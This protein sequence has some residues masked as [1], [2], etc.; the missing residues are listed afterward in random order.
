MTT[1]A[2]R[3]PAF[4]VF[5]VFLLLASGCA[6]RPFEARD[7]DKAAFLDRIVTQ[8]Q[9]AVRISA[10]VPTAE[11]VI[12]ITGLD[13]YARGIQPVWLRVENNDSRQVRVALLS[14]DS[15]YYSPME[16]AWYFR[17]GYSKDGK[18]AMERWLYEHGMPRIVPPGESRSGLVFT[19]LAEGTKGFNVDAYT[20]RQSFNFTFFVTMPGFEPDYMDVRFAELYSDD[21]IRVVDVPGLRTLLNDVDCCSV[22][23]DG[24][25]GGDPFNVVFVGTPGA[26]RRALLRSQW[27]ETR[28]G[29]A[30]S[31][32]ARRHFYRG[33]IPDGTFHKSRPDGSEQKELRIWLSPLRVGETPVWFAQASYNMS[34][35]SR[36]QSYEEYQIDPDVDDARAFVLQSFWYGQSLQKFGMAAGVPVAAFDAPRQTFTGSSWFS[37][38]G[39]AVLFIGEQPV[40]LDETEILFWETFI[41]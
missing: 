14:I 20:T 32:L 6:T 7:V 29:S 11:E 10:T 28:S 24:Q 1:G 12:A 23:S 4:G 17:K 3:T 8:Q 9:G 15:E 25:A 34:G 19:H 33:R 36:A 26:L 5:I 22:D 30:E 18:K 21:E 37:D 31:A 39:R 41:D 35:T 38:G 27:Q 13:L 2:T 40:A 16:V